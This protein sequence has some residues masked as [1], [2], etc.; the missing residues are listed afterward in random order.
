MYGRDPDLVISG[1]HFMKGS[2]YTPEE[3]RDIEDTAR[4]LGEMDTAFYTGHCTSLPAYEI[5]EKIMGPKLHPL[6]SGMEIPGL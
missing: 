5:M 3:I 2:A 4:E 1:F 6:H